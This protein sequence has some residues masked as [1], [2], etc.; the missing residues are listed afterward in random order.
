MNNNKKEPVQHPLDQFL[1]LMLNHVE[2]H[3]MLCLKLYQF[4]LYQINDEFFV[5]MHVMPLLSKYFNTITFMIHLPFQNY[6]LQII[7]FVYL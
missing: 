2:K 3:V 6:K 7:Q 1:H 5:M 4:L